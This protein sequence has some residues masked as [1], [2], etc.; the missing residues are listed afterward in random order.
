MVAAEKGALFDELKVFLTKEPGAG[1]YDA[2]A[3]R[4][5]LTTAAVATAVHRLRRRFRENVRETLAQTVST[6]LELEEEL[7]Y[8]RDVLAH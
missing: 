3:V 8:L 1:D 2:L 5:E 7:R 6:P 4:L